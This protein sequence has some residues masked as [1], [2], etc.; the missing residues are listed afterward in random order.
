MHA[1]SNRCQRC[2]SRH[3]HFATNL[4]TAGTMKKCILSVVSKKTEKL[5]LTSFDESCKY[6]EEAF[7]GKEKSDEFR[8]DIS[9]SNAPYA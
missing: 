1:F 6:W 4:V 7:Y 2:C 5:N 8:I 3:L 9:R